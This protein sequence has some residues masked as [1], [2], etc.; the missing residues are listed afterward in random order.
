MIYSLHSKYRVND[1]F[2]NAL[3]QTIKYTIS[4]SMEFDKRYK[5]VSTRKISSLMCRTRV[6]HS[7]MIELRSTRVSIAT[8]TADFNVT[9]TSF[10]DPKFDQILYRSLLIFETIAL[11]LNLFNF[12]RKVSDTRFSIPQFYKRKRFKVWSWNLIK[13]IIDDVTF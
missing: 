7:T 9:T 8:L 5:W 13:D 12:T 11:P 1:L 10:I 4:R 2:I 6:T 3:I